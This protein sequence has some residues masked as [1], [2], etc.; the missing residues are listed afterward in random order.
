MTTSVHPISASASRSDGVRYAIVAGVLLACGLWSYW[1]TM[2]ELREFFS[3]N[4]DYSVGQL[5]PFV[6]LYLVWRGRAAWNLAA[7]RPSWWG[8][9]LILAAQAFR[10]FG[11]YYW[12]VSAER[13]SLILTIAGCVLLVAGRSA[14]WRLRWVLAFLLLTIPL[15]YRVHQLIALPLQNIASVAAE[16]TLELLGYFVMRDGNIL[17]VDEKATIAVAEACSGLRMLTAF[18]FVTA[19]LAFLVRRPAWQRAAIVAS[20]LPIAIFTN[21]V[22]LVATSM[23]IVYSG[24][25]MA[26]VVFHD[27]AGLIMMPVALLIVIGE[28][29]LLA[30]LS[31]ESTV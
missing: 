25:A 29:K 1:P 12:H 26:E 9:A 30:M 6:A 16:F 14:F 24:N 7:L 13:Y 28:L 22:R 15:P 23:F 19:V 18:V 4:D 8:G 3:T 20:C 10:F 2:V 21:A 31:Q 27:Y 17:H 5:V 11:V